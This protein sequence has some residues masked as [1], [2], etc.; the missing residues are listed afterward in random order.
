VGGGVVGILLGA[1]GLLWLLGPDGD[2]IHLS[3]W[4]PDFA[5]PPRMK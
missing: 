2:V 3:R 5:L 4:L 1:Y